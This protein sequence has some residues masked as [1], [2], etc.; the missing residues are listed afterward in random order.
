M[1][2]VSISSHWGEEISKVFPAYAA[3]RLIE[4]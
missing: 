2:F 4:M 3:A 1:E